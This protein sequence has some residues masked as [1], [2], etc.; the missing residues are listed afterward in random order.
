MKKVALLLIV[1]FVVSVLLPANS[2]EIYRDNN[3]LGRVESNVFSNIL[4][5][6]LAK[7]QNVISDISF[8][9][10][11]DDLNLTIFNHNF[12]FNFINNLFVDKDN[13]KVYDGTDTIKLLNGEVVI[14]D[15]FLDLLNTI[16]NVKV[17]NNKLQISTQ[18]ASASQS[19]SNPHS[20]IMNIS[21]GVDII[22]QMLS[23]K[24]RNLNT[25]DVIVIDPGHG[26]RDPGA[27]GYNGIQEKDIALAVALKLRTHL[28]REN[29]NLRVYLTRDD[30]R[31]VPLFER[32]QIANSKKADLFISLHANSAYRENAQ[33]FETFYYHFKTDESTKIIERIE[34]NVINKYESGIDSSR[35]FIDIIKQ[36]MIQI[37]F[38]NESHNL[39]TLIQD[40]LDYNLNQVN[41]Y[42]I[43][44]RGVK[45]AK[46]L[47]LQYALMPSIL[48]ELGFISN[49]REALLLN[50]PNYQNLIAGSIAKSIIS[51]K[52]DYESQ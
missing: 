40:Y 22:G 21:G 27:I 51:Y 50:D 14:S 47:V 29:P 8:S 35:A 42:R 18:I 5:Y 45:R 19:K 13:N 30:D 32:T 41:N 38:I 46:F 24:H 11:A 31:F 37:Q 9:R 15:N 3:F 10:T 23:Q 6:S 49:K 52:E 43:M 12:Y 2:L 39:A 26:G 16:E 4:Y 48:I 44:N 17:E 34:N 7:I 1:I 25:V 28:R 33:G 20:D 36:D